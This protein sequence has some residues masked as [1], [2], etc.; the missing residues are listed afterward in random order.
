M[1]SRPPRTLADW[2]ARQDD[3]FIAALIRARP[4]IAFPAPQDLSSLASRL[5]VRI[6]VSRALDDLDAWT[7][8][9]LDGLLL[10]PSPAGADDV[11]AM[12]TGATRDDVQRAIDRLRSLALVWGEDDAVN[13]TAIVREAASRFIG[14][15][16]RPAAELLIA[17]PNDD[18]R[19]VMR[20]LRLPYASQ[21]S[22][23]AL[24]CERLRNADVVRELID[25]APDGAQQVLERLS[26]AV[27]A[28]ELA[29]ADRLPDVADAAT[30]PVRWLLAHGLLAERQHLCGRVGDGE[31]RTRRLVDADIGRLR[32]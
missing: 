28:G 24:V 9:V 8:Q 21:P 10:A 25:A 5:S 11:L 20:H 17:Y 15:L 12:L 32:R 13:V 6:S 3:A 16:G 26:G 2:L 22:A 1:T 29:H 4:D 31:K 23:T 19:T 27:P 18:I 30:P 14:G 7:L